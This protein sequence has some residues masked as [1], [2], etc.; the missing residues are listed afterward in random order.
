GNAGNDI[1]DIEKNTLDNMFA[2]KGAGVGIVWLSP[3]G[4]VQLSLARDI[5][6]NSK[7]GMV[8]FTMGPEL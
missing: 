7:Y 2:N 6:G 1:F 3:I 4:A 8:Q 5:D